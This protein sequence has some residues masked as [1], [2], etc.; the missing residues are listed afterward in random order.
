MALKHCIRVFDTEPPH[1]AE[2]G[3]LNF[4]DLYEMWDDVMWERRQKKKWTCKAKVV[5]TTAC[6][7]SNDS[8]SKVL[9]HVR[10]AH[11]GRKRQ[12]LFYYFV[13]LLIVSI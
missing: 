13:T 3:I 4:T 1:D 8:L 11:F 10:K 7:K 5:G 2:T 12:L 6:E 9:E